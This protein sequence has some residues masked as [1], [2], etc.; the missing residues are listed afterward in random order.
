MKLL[1][2]VDRERKFHRVSRAERV[3][4]ARDIYGADFAEAVEDDFDI[5]AVAGLSK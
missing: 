5:S 1:R 2:N 3:G 4:K